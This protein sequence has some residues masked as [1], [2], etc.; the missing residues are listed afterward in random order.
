MC[1]ESPGTAS[2]ET[3]SGMRARKVCMCVCAARVMRQSE[4]TVIKGMWKNLGLIFWLDVFGAGS[5]V[6]NKIRGGKESCC[7]N[8]SKR[9]S[10]GTER[11]E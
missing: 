10:G 7:R 6:S 8:D 5:H 4:R 3:D 11:D 9:I 2:P 1:D